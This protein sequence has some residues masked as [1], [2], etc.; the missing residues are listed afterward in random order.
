MK[1]IVSRRLSTLA[2]GI[3]DCAYQRVS[4]C[5]IAYSHHLNIDDS[6]EA[7]ASLAPEFLKDATLPP[8]LMCF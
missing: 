7:L 5:N 4:S 8:I 3:H 6:D 1:P 2:A